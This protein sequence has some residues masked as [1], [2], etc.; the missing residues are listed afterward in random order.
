M[1]NSI[2]FAGLPANI[3]YL[4]YGDIQWIDYDNDGDLDII[5]SGQDSN[6]VKMTKLFI[7]NGNTNFSESEIKFTDLYLST[8]SVI[9]FNQDGYMDFIISGST[10]KNEYKTILYKNTVSGFEECTQILFD[11]VKEAV[12]AWGDYDND[13][14]LDLFI[15]GEIEYDRR[16]KITK[17]YKNLGNSMFSEINFIFPNS[18]ISKISTADWV[19]INGDNKLDLI[20]TRFSRPLTIYINKGNDKFTKHPITD[21]NCSYGDVEVFD[22]DLDNDLDIVLNGEVTWG[23]YVTKLL[24]NEGNLMFQESNNE[25][26][27]CSQ[28]STLALDF[29]NDN[30]LDLLI[31]G[32]TGVR[33]PA[34]LIYETKLYENKNCELIELDLEL[35]NTNLSRLGDFDNDG[36]MDILM[37]NI[38]DKGREILILINLLKE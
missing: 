24:L 37:G 17:V 21:Y 35:P 7:N 14:D 31:C 33:L 18:N 22:F 10:A 6:Q 2:E 11:N 19:D 16:E 27:K 38:T 15:S 25:L 8:I 36:D 12:F 9:D 1:D 13:N 30:D 26:L 4:H 23:K 29:D 28:G 5:T 34:T 20:I 32:R 3:P